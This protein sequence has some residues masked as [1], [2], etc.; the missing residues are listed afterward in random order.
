MMPKFLAVFLFG[1]FVAHAETRDWRS[2]DGSKSFRGEFVKQIGDKVTIRNEAGK[3]LTFP[4]AKLH[5]DDLQ[6]L[7]DQSLKAA[8]QA[9]VF[10][11]IRFGETE[12]QLFERLKT[13]P[14]VIMPNRGKESD[15]LSLALLDVK[16][17][18]KPG[19]AP[20]SVS[21]TWSIENN[22]NKLYSID[23]TCEPEELKNYDAK[24]RKSHDEMTELLI[25]IHGKPATTAPFPPRESVKENIISPTSTWTFADHSS[26]EVGVGLL[27]DGQ[28]VAASRFSAPV[29]SDPI[30]QENS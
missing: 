20:A 27:Q 8:V 21:F 30:E 23:I 5:A 26:L 13:N 10:G 14:H 17:K 7:K 6:W 15:N 2:A 19:G 22:V 24:L 4:T 1:I 25:S 11:G 16:T 3:E 9:G 29:P 28:Y 18:M 12:A